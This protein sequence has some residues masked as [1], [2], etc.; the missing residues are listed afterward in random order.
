MKTVSYFYHKNIAKDHSVHYAG[1]VR[2][3]KIGDQLKVVYHIRD[4]KSKKTMSKK[5]AH[6]RV[7]GM[8]NGRHFMEIPYSDTMTYD[9]FSHAMG[10]KYQKMTR[11]GNISEINITAALSLTANS[12]RGA[13][14]ALTPKLQSV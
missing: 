14:I 5:M 10:Q 6:V 9:D 13:L 7:D 12:F 1:I 2:M 11:P 4:N 8:A 3:E